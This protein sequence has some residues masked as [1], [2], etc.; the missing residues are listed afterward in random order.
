MILTIVVFIFVLGL[1]IFVHE[2]GHF[3]A[4][5]KA[6]IKVR[7]PLTKLR[8]NLDSE[9]TKLIERLT[10]SRWHDE[11]TQL[12]RD[13]LNVKQIIF[14]KGKRELAVE[15]DAKITPA[16]KEEGD[17]REL[18]HQI[19]QLRRQADCRLDQK[20]IVLAPSLPDN[21]AL[22]ALL[23]EKVLAQKLTLAKTLQIKPL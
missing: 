10:P 9:L 8:V 1:F 23:K 20:I 7:Q 16:L 2:L 6:G 19:Q 15:L 11:L 18:I 12:I 5:K 4:A 14:K 3:I 22:H 13:E 17:V 21:P